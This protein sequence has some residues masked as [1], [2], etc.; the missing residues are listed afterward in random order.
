MKKLLLFII[1][2]ICFNT[3]KGQTHLY[4]WLYCTLANN[5]HPTSFFIKNGYV[6]INENNNKISIPQLNINFSY[7]HVEKISGHVMYIN[8]DFGQLIIADNLSM[9][10]MEY[11]T[12]DKITYEFTGLKSI[13]NK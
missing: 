13:T 8:N 11:F 6:V 3:A 4:S 12:G 2:L 10:R 5:S 7:K 9:M 1:V